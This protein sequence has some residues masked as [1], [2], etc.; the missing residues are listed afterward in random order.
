MDVRSKRVFAETN[1][2]AVNNDLDHL[3]WQVWYELEGQVPRARIR[4]VAMQV[5]AAFHDAPLSIH[6]PLWVRYLTREWLRQEIARCSQN[7]GDGVFRQAHPGLN[8]LRGPSF[9]S[10]LVMMH[11]LLR[12]SP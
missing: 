5:L 9:W 7:A 3:I 8:I 12:H 4:Q 6:I 1:S 11:S 2:G 10:P